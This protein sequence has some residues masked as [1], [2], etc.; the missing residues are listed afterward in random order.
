[1]SLGNK[2]GIYDVLVVGA[3]AAG[4]LSAGKAAQAG[5]KTLLLEKNEKVGRKI[6]I[7]GKGRCNVTN[8]SELP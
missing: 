6:G 5:A 2:Q 8:L 7:T 3:G 4:M 1:M